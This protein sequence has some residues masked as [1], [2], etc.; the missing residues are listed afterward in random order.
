MLLINQRLDKLSA[1]C[2]DFSS[3]GMLC[4]SSSS[5]L[6]TP[7]ADPNAEDDDMGDINGMWAHADIKLAKQPGA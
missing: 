3:H 1:A 5:I 6:S 7:H 4:G 2:I